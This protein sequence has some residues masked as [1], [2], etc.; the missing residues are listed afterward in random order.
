MMQYKICV[1]VL[2]VRASDALWFIGNKQK[3]FGIKTTI[4]TTD[5]LTGERALMYMQEK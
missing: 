3:R 4:K 2:S 5:K 1:K